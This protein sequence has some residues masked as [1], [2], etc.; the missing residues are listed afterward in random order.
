MNPRTLVVALAPLVVAAAT[1]A[2]GE[3]AHA[4]C[5]PFSE[6]ADADGRASLLADRFSLRPIAGS[7][8]V[9]RSHSVMA[10]AHSNTSETRLYLQ[11]GDSRFVVFAEE[12]WALAGDD[13]AATARTYAKLRFR[14]SEADAT[15]EQ[16]TIGKNA[17]AVGLA[18]KKLDLTRKAVAA[19]LVVVAHTDGTMQTI[20]FFVT[21]DVAKAEGAAAACTG[22]ARK[23]AKTL[24]IGK[25]T[26]RRDGRRVAIGLGDTTPIADLALPAGY[27][28]HSTAGPDFTVHQLSRL[29]TFGTPSPSLGIYFGGHPRL[30]DYEGEATTKPGTLFGADVTW[31]DVV[32][33][34]RHNRQ[35]IAAVAGHKDVQT[36]VFMTTPSRSELAELMRVVDG[37]LLIDKNTNK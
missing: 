35:L 18:P 30:H 9:Q 14:W 27:V 31:S 34:T 11:H 22:L 23:Q 13:L 29:A 32:T 20:A 26:I 28:L 15:V 1:L 24:V 16:L 36:H 2:F 33:P 37:M 12:Q 17:R 8:A 5:G 6:L 21:P 10:A 7:K 19:Y 4:T 25:R 3:M